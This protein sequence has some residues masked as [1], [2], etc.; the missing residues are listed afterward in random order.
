MG[1]KCSIN[2]RDHKGTKLQVGK[3]KGKKSPWKTDA[4]EEDDNIKL[5]RTKA[6]EYKVVQK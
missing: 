4:L 1:C 2:E 6:S 5:H 3:S